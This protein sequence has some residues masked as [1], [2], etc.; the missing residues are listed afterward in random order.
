MTTSPGTGSDAEPAG[1]QIPGGDVKLAGARRIAGI[2][3]QLLNSLENKYGRTLELRE[4]RTVV[5]DLTELVSKGYTTRDEFAMITAHVLSV[6]RLANSRSGELTTAQKQR[7]SD[8]QLK[9]WGGSPPQF[10]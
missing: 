1:G 8:G 7:F 4:F 5:V 9:F 10:P 2:A 3:V 6:S